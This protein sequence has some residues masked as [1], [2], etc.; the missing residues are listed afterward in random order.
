MQINYLA[1]SMRLLLGVPLTGTDA[2]PAGYQVSRID[3]S[4]GEAEPFFRTRPEALDPEGAESVVTSGPKHPV[5]VRAD[6]AEGRPGRRAA[7]EPFPNPSRANPR[8]WDGE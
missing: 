7:R 2:P 6:H 8:G 3:L 4:T 1:Y 5:D